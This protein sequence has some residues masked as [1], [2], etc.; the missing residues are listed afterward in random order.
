MTTSPVD[1]GRFDLIQNPRILIMLGEINLA[2][3]RR[4]TE[5]LYNSID[6]FLVTVG[7]GM[8]RKADVFVPLSATPTGNPRF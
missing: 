7:E 1:T 5:P 2:Q 8:P 6:G 4:M 3:C